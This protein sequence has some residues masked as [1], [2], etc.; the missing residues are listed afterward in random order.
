MMSM[1]K[2]TEFDA[3]IDLDSILPVLIHPIMQNGEVY[4]VFEVPMKQRN[5]VKSEKDK[6]MLGSSSIVGID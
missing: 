6:I 2:T 1:R 3:T 4:A 5:L